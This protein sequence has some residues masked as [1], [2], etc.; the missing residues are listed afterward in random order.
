[1]G[2][3][4]LPFSKSERK[5]R[6]TFKQRSIRTETQACPTLTLGLSSFKHD[7]SAAVLEDGTVKAAIE[8]HELTASEAPVIPR[9]ATQF[10]GS[11]PSAIT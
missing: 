4:S 6:S 9:T 5:F 11:K 3:Q 7:T 10:L 2:V 1:M 8:E